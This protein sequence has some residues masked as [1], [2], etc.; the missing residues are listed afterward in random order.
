MV[1]AK[2]W[3]GLRKDWRGLGRIVIMMSAHRGRLQGR[4]L[5]WRDNAV[6]HFQEDPQGIRVLQEW[7]RAER[8]KE[9]LL[10]LTLPVV[11]EA[12]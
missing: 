4:R 8:R 3:R 2:N 5:A 7:V 10:E 6:S 1:E 12:R 9:D 11:H